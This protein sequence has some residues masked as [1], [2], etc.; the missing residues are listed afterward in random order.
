M[1]TLLLTHQDFGNSSFNLKYKVN[2]APIKIFSNSFIGANSIIM[3]GITIGKSSVVGAGALVNKNVADKQIVAGIPA[4]NLIAI[5]N[6][7]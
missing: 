6:S 2:H 5:E 3:M 1:N 4:K 7:K